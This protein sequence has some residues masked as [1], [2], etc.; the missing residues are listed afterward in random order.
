MSITIYL[1]GKIGKNDWRHK[2]MPGLR[3]HS[4]SLGSI[5]TRD[6]TY[7]GPFFQSC[8]HGCLHG[9]STHGVGAGTGTCTE[10]IIYSPADII[11]LNDAALQ[12]AD[13]VFAYITAIDCHG[14]MVEIGRASNQPFT[15][16]VIAFAPGIDSKDFWYATKRA[17]A[18]HEHVRECCLA[19]ILASEL[20]VTKGNSASM[21]SGL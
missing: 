17:A 7:A 18:V 20:S 16:I 3:G 12:K 21:G 2:L 10:E 8:D 6:F 1:A 15:R 5:A 4:W 19:E 9:P 14:T 11:R 13:L